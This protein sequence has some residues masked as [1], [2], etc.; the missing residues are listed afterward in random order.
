M[1]FYF[2]EGVVCFDDFLIL[3]PETGC[4]MSVLSNGPEQGGLVVG[5]SMG[6]QI[7]RDLFRNVA[8]VGQILRLYSKNICWRRGAHRV[9]RVAKCRQLHEWVRGLDDTSNQHR[10]ASHLLVLYPWSEVNWER[11]TEIFKV[12]RQSL[13]YRGDA[14]PGWS[15]DY[16]IN[17]WGVIFGRGLFGS[18]KT[19]FAESVGGRGGQLS[20]S[21]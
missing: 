13:I 1:V 18:I 14:T 21:F 20:K 12:A 15:L 7:I 2:D 9:D 3:N 10:R 19:G 16:K 17:F 6:D 11:V 5:A 4:L 8:A